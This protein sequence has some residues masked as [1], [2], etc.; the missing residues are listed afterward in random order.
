MLDA[1]IKG[2]FD[3]IPHHIIMTGLS[4][5][6]AD[7]NILD[8]TQKFLESGVMDNGVF[9]PTNIG[10]PKAESFLRFWLISLLTLLI[11]IFTIMGFVL[12]DM[13]TILWW[14]ANPKRRLK[15]LWIRLKPF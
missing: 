12:C 4:N 11:G 2:F 13:R 10:T 6:V 15:R 1:D 14:Y 7:G 3:N 9:K 8:L 5:V